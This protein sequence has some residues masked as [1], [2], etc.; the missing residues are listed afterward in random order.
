[1]LNDYAK[2]LEYYMAEFKSEN[3]DLTK[4]EILL[5]INKLYMQ[6][7]KTRLNHFEK[8]EYNEVALVAEHKID[9]YILML[10]KFYQ[11]YDLLPEHDSKGFIESLSTEATL[12]VLGLPDH[13]LSENLES[14]RTDLATDCRII[15][16]QEELPFIKVGSNVVISRFFILNAKINKIEEMLERQAA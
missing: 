15:L 10:S 6:M 7:V 3:K 9:E 5:K 16:M 12:Y 14:L 11:L 13:G 1:M 4:D 8:Y 2:A